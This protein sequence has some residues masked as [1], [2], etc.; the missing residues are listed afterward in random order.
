MRA[1]FAKRLA[2]V[3]AN[4]AK[5]RRADAPFLSKKKPHR[6]GRAYAGRVAA[7]VTSFVAV[8]SSGHR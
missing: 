7:V 5:Q 1:V 4:A 6:I 2:E 8:R 3:W